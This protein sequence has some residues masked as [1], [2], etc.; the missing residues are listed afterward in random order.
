[1]HERTIAEAIENYRTLSEH[2]L[3]TG[4]DDD[5]G[6]RRTYPCRGGERDHAPRRAGSSTR[7]AWFSARAT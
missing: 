3:K 7:S 1:M 5:D 6:G 4:L 2:L